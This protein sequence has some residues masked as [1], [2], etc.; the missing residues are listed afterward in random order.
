MKKY[1]Y[2]ILGGGTTAGYAAEEFVNQ[3][4]DKDQL[5]IISKEKILPMNR[6]PFSKGYLYGGN[7]EDILIQDQNYYDR[8]GIEILS[9]TKA[10]NIDFNKKL[11]TINNNSDEINYNKLLIATGSKVKKLNIPGAENNVYYLRTMED[12][13]KIRSKAVGSK[14]AVVIGGQFIASEVAASL[15]MLGLNVTL[16]YP[17]EYLMNSFDNEELGIFFNYLFSSK[18]VHL[19][20]NTQAVEIKQKEEAKK[21]ILDSGD[22]IEADMI[23]AGVGAEPDTALFKSTELVI[24]D[25]IIV[26]KYCETS[27]SDVYAAGDVAVFPDNVFGK[28]RRLE[29]WQNAYDQGK[30]A[31]R[32]M[33]GHYFEY[34]E[35]PYFFSDLFEYSYEFWG[36]ISNS[37][38]YIIKGNPN[39]GNFSIFWMHED[40]IIAAFISQKRPDTERTKAKEWII[41]KQR[42]NVE[43]LRQTDVPFEVT[44]I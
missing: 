28:L 23:I 26:N 14:K 36:D 37:D 10:E 42:I 20:K 32:N 4:I 18:G 35:I 24:N 43:L 38:D 31:A 41:N 9:G 19:L 21:I 40:I 13:E 44:L 3:N 39:K 30:L 27:I 12:A 17:H 8:H 6:P 16:I 15:R 34:T 29:H 1:E 22:M 5:F 2:V 25:G 33:A 11:I 7:T